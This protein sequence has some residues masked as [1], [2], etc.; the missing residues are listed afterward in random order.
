[1]L[2]RLA[3]LFL[4][5]AVAC[6]A[7]AE[8]LRVESPNGAN[9]VSFELRDGAPYYSV[10]RFDNE[11]IAASRMGFKLVDHA[12]LAGGFEVVATD[13]NAVDDQ[14]TQPWG[15]SHLV[16]DK[17]NELRVTLQQTGESGGRLVVVFRVFDD[18]VGFR[19]EFP[20]QD[21][22]KEFEI[23]DELT[24]F[25]LTEDARCWWVPAF[26][27]NRYEYLYETTPVSKTGSVHTPFTYQT[28]D[29]LCVS[30]HEAALVDY[31]SMALTNTGDLRLQADLYPW[32]DGVKVKTAA[33]MK[34]PWR[35]VQLG[36]SA[37]D[38]ITS[39]LILNLNEPCKLQDTS[40]IKP[41]KY[42][43]VWW[44][45][46]VGT[47]TWGS[48]PQHGATTENVKHFIDFASKYGFD[49]VLVE[50][51]NEGWDGDWM[52][53]GAQF[54]FTKPY[55]DFDMEELSRY[56]QQ[57][58]VYLVGHHET[59]GDIANYERQLDDAYHYYVDHGVKA[60]KSGY[61]DF[62]DGIDRIDES[63]KRHG[64]WHHGQFMV[65]HYQHAL[66][67]A[68]KH[69][70][71]VIA[72]EP[73]KDTGLR[74]TW[75]N[76]ISREGARGQEYNA[77]GG[78][79]GNPPEHTAILPFTRMLS[80]PMDF[81]PGVFDLKL[82]TG[83]RPNNS[84][85]TTL[86][87]Q[88]A[89]YVVIYTPMQMAVDFPEVYEQHL[90]AFQFIRDVP[91]DW[92][93]TRVLNASIGDYVTVVRRERGGEDYFLGA[94]TDE[95]GRVLSTPLSFLERDRTYI[96]QIYRDADDAHWDTNPQAYVVHEREV[97][98]NTILELRLAPGG[99]QAIRFT[100]K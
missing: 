14:W 79:G 47:H 30:I 41:G 61:V 29:G 55:P 82:N 23:A 74:R 25:A 56:A 27:D 38:L 78:E 35:T 9:R 63:G 100:P 73:I 19:Y 34:T 49:G 94:V 24:E 83:D 84:V 22:L 53:N 43:G 45:M 18:G 16:R 70:I 58:D 31:S 3:S 60:V 85:N 44:G 54:N 67:Q 46:H 92:Q 37:A 71:M 81:T 80:G 51:W 87:K 6:D 99:G 91:T 97:D 96:A 10:S 12:D 11:V 89:L 93:E 62:A 90:D 36:D 21:G 68:A 15:E 52:N 17:H 50:G 33:P 77:W 26:S 57:R 95:N 64:E 5:L 1:M 76:A 72:H 4:M 66:E 48:G 2:N 13:R 59:A 28:S 42:V 7:T 8:T 88:L 32:S 39:H 40:W 69:Q 98:A 75:P 20:E 86:A 65:R